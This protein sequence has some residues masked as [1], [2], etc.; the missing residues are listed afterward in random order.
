MAWEMMAGARDVSRLE[1][2]YIYFFLILIYFTTSIH[3]D[4][5]L[6]FDFN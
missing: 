2:R 5:L 6:N 3:K 4:R 1:P